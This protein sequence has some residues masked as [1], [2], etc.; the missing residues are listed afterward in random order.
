MSGTQF[1]GNTIS[2]TLRADGGGAYGN[3]ATTITNS[4]F[5]DNVVT[6]SDGGGLY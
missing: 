4:Q 5:I 3:G 2:N 1:I 6:R